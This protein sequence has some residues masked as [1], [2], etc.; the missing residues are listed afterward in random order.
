MPMTMSPSSLPRCFL[1]ERNSNWHMRGEQIFQREGTLLLE[2][3]LW[4]PNQKHLIWR[5]G[6]VLSGYTMYQGHTKNTAWKDH[7]VS[8]KGNGEWVELCDQRS[9]WKLFTA[10]LQGWLKLKLKA[11]P[12]SLGKQVVS[13]SLWSESGFWSDWPAPHFLGQVNYYTSSVYSLICQME[14]ERMTMVLIS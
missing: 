14:M 5:R 8:D 11:C 2:I 10:E 6:D 4:S 9:P 3:K 13:C 1:L 12:R 7:C